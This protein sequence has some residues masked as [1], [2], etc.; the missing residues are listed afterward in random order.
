LDSGGI[1]ASKDYWRCIKTDL[2]LRSCADQD[3][4][5][6]RQSRN[7]THT[8]SLL[9]FSLGDGKGGMKQIGYD[10]VW[11]TKRG[12][13]VLRMGKAVGVIYLYI[14]GEEC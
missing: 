13:A 1:S 12:S 8:R 2:S 7:A 5:R 6:R 9:D 10:V 3:G 11:M 14:R 4:D